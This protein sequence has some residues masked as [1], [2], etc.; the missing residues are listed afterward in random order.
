MTNEVFL[1]YNAHNMEKALKRRVGFGCRSE[2]PGLVERGRSEDAEHGL[3]AGV[4]MR[5]SRVC[6]L[7]LFE[8][9][10]A[11]N[12]GGTASIIR[13]PCFCKGDVFCFFRRFEYVQQL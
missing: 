11:A 4:S 13:R 1:D 7:S 5:R 2:S 6:P 3:G 9:A 8:A 10:Y 12:Q